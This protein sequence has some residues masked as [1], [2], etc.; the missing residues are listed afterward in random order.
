MS[1]SPLSVAVVGVGYFGKFHA[2]KVANLPQTELVAVSD[3][4]FKLAKKIAK[5]YR[6]R[7]VGDYRELLGEVDAVCIAVPTQYHC[8]IASDFLESGV[9]VLVEKPITPDLASA[10]RLVNIA[11]ERDR[12]LQVGHLERFSGVVEALRKYVVRP[13]YI[14]SVRISPFKARS[15][16]VN[17]ILDVMIH[18]LDLILSLLDA[19]IL[20]VDAAGAPVFSDSEDIASVRIKF[21]DGCVA[22]IVASRISLKSERKMR[23]FEHDKYVAVD[24]E[25]RNIRVVWQSEGN[26]PLMPGLPPIDMRNEDYSEGD[27]L[28]R[29]IEAFAQAVANRTAPIV[30]GEA[31]MAALEAAVRVNESLKAHAEFIGTGV[32]PVKSQ[33][34]A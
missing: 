27:A 33:Q 25:K 19:P 18:D 7:A 4:D 15:T 11:R 3:T 9:D 28:E 31:G 30:S 1:N 34:L 32:A 24:L 13:L 20:T 21:A 8:E 14:D 23:I 10:E 17:V 5:K 6:T 2:E 29:E 12:I 16:D 26:K 22:N